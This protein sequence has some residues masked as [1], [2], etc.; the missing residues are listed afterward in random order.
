MLNCIT[1]GEESSREIQRMEELNKILMAHEIK[2][3]HFDTVYL[4]GTSFLL[5]FITLS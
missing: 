5:G 2:K 3:N 1:K 4:A